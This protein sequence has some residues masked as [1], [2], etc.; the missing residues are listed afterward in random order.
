MIYGALIFRALVFELSIYIVVYMTNES[1][2]FFKMLITVSFKVC[3]YRF[4]LSD[5]EFLAIH[6]QVKAKART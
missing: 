4:N 3:A 6:G 1:Q 5:K 2:G